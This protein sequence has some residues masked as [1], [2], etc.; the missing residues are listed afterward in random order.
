[1]GTIV[2]Y[3]GFHIFGFN[4]NQPHERIRA[5]V[6]INQAKSKGIISKFLHPGN[7]ND[8]AYHIEIKVKN[9]KLIKCN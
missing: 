9:C 4:N 8:P 5:V 1:M 3:S 7:S 2:N 6:G